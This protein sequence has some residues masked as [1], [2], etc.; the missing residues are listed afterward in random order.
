MY[1]NKH[2]PPHFHALHGGRRMTVEIESGAVRGDL[3]PTAVR[4]VLEWLA[5]HRAELRQNW[6]LARE[7][8]PLLR[9]AP[10]E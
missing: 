9:V 2:G 7:R 5:L 4:L 1:Y 3:P 6:V 8:R 10:L